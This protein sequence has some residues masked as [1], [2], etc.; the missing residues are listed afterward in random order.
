ME[1]FH[2]S[3]VVEVE[4]TD[5]DLPVSR[6]GIVF[7]RGVGVGEVLEEE[8]IWVPEVVVQ[9]DGEFGM[10]VLE[11]EPRSIRHYPSL[12]LAHRPID[13]GARR[14]RAKSVDDSGS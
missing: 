14:L 2:P 13:W 1:A 8:D 6:L 4:P 12:I 10:V 11:L 3:P 5:I 9:I 7:R